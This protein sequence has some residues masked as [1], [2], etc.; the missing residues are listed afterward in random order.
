MVHVL[1]QLLCCPT[2]YAFFEDVR[3]PHQVAVAGLPAAK[4]A[5]H[6]AQQA[7]RQPSGWLD[8]GHGA[9]RTTPGGSGS[10]D[11][12]NARETPTPPRGV[13]PTYKPSLNPKPASAQKRSAPGADAAAAG[14]GRARGG[15]GLGSGRDGGLAPGSGRGGR[16]GMGKRKGGGGGGAA[17]A[18]TAAAAAEARALALAEPQT[19]R[20][21]MIAAQVGCSLPLRSWS[22]G[23][24]P[25]LALAKQLALA[26][27]QRQTDQFSHFSISG[28]G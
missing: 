7:G 3:R 12:G 9:A 6:T 16:S 2:C 28:V 24:V 26:K 21:A 15:V 10:E 18:A 25:L 14:K 27:L 4:R 17:S 20:E 8:N 23:A 11:A 5:K 19:E 1:L 13:D 22:F